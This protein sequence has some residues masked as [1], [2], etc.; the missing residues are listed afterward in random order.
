VGS[1]DDHRVFDAGR[2]GDAGDIRAEPPILEEPEPSPVAEPSPSVEPS[3]SP[4]VSPTPEPT[5]TPPPTAPEWTM[6]FASDLLGEP[7]S[8]TLVSSKVQ[9][10]AGKAVRFSQTVTGSLDGPK[11]T[12]TRIY[13]EYWGSGEGK[14]G[15]AEFWL[16]LDTPAGRYEYRATASLVSVTA[17]EDGN[18]VYGFTG[19]YALTTAPAAAEAG[20][21]HDGLITLE[22]SFLVDG[23]LADGTSLYRTGMELVESTG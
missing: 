20:M 23:T 5:E 18:A 8:L 21:P 6:S 2:T 19:S 7:S 14:A 12:V 4:E 11:D 10:K 22:L 13:L 1:P 17:A 9:G 3:P 16:F 15:S